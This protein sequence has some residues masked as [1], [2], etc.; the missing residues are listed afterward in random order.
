[1]QYLSRKLLSPLTVSH[2]VSQA[3]VQWC[4][5][6]SLQPPPPGFKQLSRHSL[7]SSWDYRWNLTLLPRLECSGAVF[8]LCLPDSSDSPASTSIAGT[9]ST[10][11]HAQEPV[12]IR[13]M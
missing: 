7:P 1:M 2:S 4:H 9:T 10:H 6:G 13:K 11:H 8:N 3:R 5:L 12:V